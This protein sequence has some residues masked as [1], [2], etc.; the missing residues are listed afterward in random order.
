MARKWAERTERIRQARCYFSRRF[1]IHTADVAIRYLLRMYGVTVGERT[2]RCACLEEK[3]RIPVA[4]G[5]VISRVSLH[6]SAIL[7]R[8][9]FKTA[10]ILVKWP[11]KTTVS[12]RSAAV[13]T[14]A[15]SSKPHFLPMRL[16]PR[17]R[18][19]LS[20]GCFRPPS[21]P[22]YRFAVNS[23]RLRSHQCTNNYEGR[24]SM[25]ALLVHN[26]GDT[27]ESRC[28]YSSL[29]PLDPTSSRMTS[30]CLQLRAL[31]PLTVSPTQWL[32]EGSPG[33]GYRRHQP[34][35]GEPKAPI[36][37]YS[38]RSRGQC[39]R[40]LTYVCRNTNKRSYRIDNA[41]RLALRVLPEARPRVRTDAV[42]LLN[43]YPSGIPASCFFSKL[44]ALQA[45]WKIP[46]VAYFDV[47]HQHSFHS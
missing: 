22:F 7:Q 26:A 14:P 33:S 2:I 30:K 28:S 21:S 31:L 42:L 4:A 24:R 18:R 11:L 8:A 46:K 37:N 13:P 32:V 45:V 12:R 3:V 36:T 19:G 16:F 10:G 9:Y 41:V 17:R 47:R 40:L 20:A 43:T 35:R 15:T 29:R 38:T 34:R 6:L 27:A 5:P 23:R 1:R 39:A 44:E 25:D